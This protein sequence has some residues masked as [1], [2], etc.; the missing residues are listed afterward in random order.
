MKSKYLKIVAM[1]L[2]TIVTLN[3]CRESIDEGARFTFVG[4]TVATY[5]EGEEMQQAVQGYYDVLYQANPASVGG[6]MPYD[7]FYYLP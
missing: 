1:G 3:S 7:D 2:A 4:N 5:L 6:A